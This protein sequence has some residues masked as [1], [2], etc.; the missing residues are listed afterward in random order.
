MPSRTRPAW[1]TTRSADTTPGTGTRPC[2]GSR[3]HRR[4][5]V[6]GAA[7]RRLGIAVTVAVTRRPGELAGN[8]GY[9]PG[10]ARTGPRAIPSATLNAP[11]PGSARRR[12]IGR[13]VERK[14][15]DWGV[16]AIT[17]LKVYRASFIS[18]ALAWVCLAGFLLVGL[19]MVTIGPHEHGGVLGVVIGALLLVFSL[20][21]GAVLATNR[22]IVTPPGLIYWNYL[23]RKSIGWP[24]I[25]SFGVGPGRSRMRWPALV[26]HLD[27]GS[28]TAT[29]LASF[30]RKYPARIADELDALQRQLAPASLTGCD[31]PTGG[32][33]WV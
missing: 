18:I 9:R 13:R 8:G 30:T 16:M 33:S 22:L 17:E 27:D 3:W 24:E 21:A 1:T 10:P 11:L 6:P 12:T 14:L 26:I 31:P 29:N 15:T 25:R 5:L 23:R 32:S 7:R 2:R 4:Q 20:W 28:V 19:S